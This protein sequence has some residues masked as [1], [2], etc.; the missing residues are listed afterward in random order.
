MLK[1]YKVSLFLHLARYLKKKITRNKPKINQNL[2]SSVQRFYACPT[3]S[4][5]SFCYDLHELMTP[6][7]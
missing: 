7:L 1:F 2:Y 3:A 4:F 6:L 5:Y